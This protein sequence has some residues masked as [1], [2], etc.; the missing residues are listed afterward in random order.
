MDESGGL[1]DFGDLEERIDSTLSEIEDLLLTKSLYSHV[2]S[3][4][5]SS[6]AQD[7]ENLA[8]RI[9]ALNVLELGLEH[10][11]VDLG[12]EDEGL[13]GWEGQKRSAR[14][15]VE[16]LADMVGKG[17]QRNMYPPSEHS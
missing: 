1:E 16:D 6:D 2:F 13:P 9:A 4:P 11:G 3:P 10:L 5:F 7:D 17:A 8:S 12:S 14:E 15:T